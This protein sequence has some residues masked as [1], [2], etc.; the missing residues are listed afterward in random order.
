[1]ITKSLEKKLPKLSRKEKGY[2]TD[3]I[4]TENGTQSA[5]NNYDTTNYKT[6][7]AISSENLDKPRIQQAIEIVKTHYAERFSEED[8]YDKHQALLN[9]K[10]WDR[11]LIEDEYGNKTIKR[12]ETD[13]ID[14]VAVKA[15]L[16]MFYKIKGSYAP[17]KIQVPTDAKTYNFYFDP[18]FQKNIK[19]YEDNLKQQILNAQTNTNTTQTMETNKER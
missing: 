8:I 2:I 10:I 18:A 13:E 3:F 1:M 16:D 14:P 6:A 5:L 11:E 19:Q 17:D 9:K 12:I 15:G 4:V 7:S